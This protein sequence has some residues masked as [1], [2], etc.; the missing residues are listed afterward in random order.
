MAQAHHF[1][2]LEGFLGLTGYYRKFIR[3]YGAI[4]KPLTDL[5]KKDAY[6]WSPKAE[7]AFEELKSAMT[8]APV[9][10]LPNFSKTFMV[11]CDASGSGIGAVL[12]Q[13]NRPLAFLARPSRGANWVSPLT[14]R[15]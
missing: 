7:E 9:L 12:L 14:K 15:R 8:Q 10:A 11:E 5:L 3:N 13:D 4:A 1:E 6:E 2:G